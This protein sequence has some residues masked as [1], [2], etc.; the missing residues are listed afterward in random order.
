MERRR[1]DEVGRQVPDGD[2]AGAGRDLIGADLRQGESIDFGFRN[3]FGEA[4][5]DEQ[6]GRFDGGAGKSTSAPA[7][8]TR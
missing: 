2:F 7:P 3:L 4:R 6:P 5:A 8:S 1:Q